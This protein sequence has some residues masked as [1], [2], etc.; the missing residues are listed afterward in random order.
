MARKLATFCPHKWK[1]KPLLANG[2]AA[3]GRQEI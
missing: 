3:Q 2:L 1:A